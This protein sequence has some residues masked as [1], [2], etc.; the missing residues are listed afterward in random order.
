LE[1]INNLEKQFKHPKSKEIHDGKKAYVFIT[2]S[3][4]G[5][6]ANYN[7]NETTL[8][9]I[10]N[11]DLEGEFINNQERDYYVLSRNIKPFQELEEVYD[12]VNNQEEKDFTLQNYISPTDYVIF[13]L[14]QGNS[15]YQH[16]GTF[17]IVDMKTKE[18]KKH[19]FLLNFDEKEKEIEEKYAS[20][21]K[22]SIDAIK[23]LKINNTDYISKQVIEEFKKVTSE[24]E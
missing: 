15:P 3:K 8:E 13:K 10:C 2:E 6:N 12:K 11:D 14:E 1:E 9:S 23:N 5:G 22:E 18:V 24:L 19:S 20:Y 4:L 16:L 21:P 7:L 17:T